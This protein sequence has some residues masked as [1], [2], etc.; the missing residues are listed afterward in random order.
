VVDE[1]GEILGLVT[2]EDILE[3]IVGEF[4]TAPSSQSKQITVKKDGSAWMEGS[5]HVREVNK[6]L[7]IKLPTKTG[8]TMNGL[9][10]EYLE[11]IP[12]ANM[13][14]KINDYPIEVR[15]IQNNAVKTLVIYPRRI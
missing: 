1:Y 6:Q 2:L 7:G 9:I 4:S 11:A 5:I 14:V 3:D 8:K 13:C 12:V 10:L 15:K